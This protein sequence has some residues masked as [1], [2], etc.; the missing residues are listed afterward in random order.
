MDFDTWLGA[1]ARLHGPSMSTVILGIDVG[2]RALF[3]ML[4][5][6]G[7]GGDGD[8]L[9]CNLDLFP[10]WSHRRFF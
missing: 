3:I 4:G 2:T 9:G 8:W 10:D 5:F 6:D 1:R 7:G